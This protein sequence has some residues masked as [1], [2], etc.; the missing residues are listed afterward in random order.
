MIF[1]Q[2]FSG[3]GIIPKIF[4]ASFIIPAILFIEPLGLYCSEVS[5][6][7]EE[8]LNITLFSSSSLFIVFLSA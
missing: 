6:D 2:A 3:C 1:S 8:Y 5:P 7:L 4:P